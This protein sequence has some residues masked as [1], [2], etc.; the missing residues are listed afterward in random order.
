LQYLSKQGLVKI[1]LTLGSCI[2]A[3]QGCYTGNKDSFI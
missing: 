1:F 3:I 2:S